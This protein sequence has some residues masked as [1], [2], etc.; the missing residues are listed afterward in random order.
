MK[1]FVSLCVSS[2][3]SLSYV[4]VRIL[5]SPTARNISG[6]KRSYDLPF[7]FISPLPK[8]RRNG[9][10]NNKLP[11]T[12]E[13]VSRA[14]ATVFR[15]GYRSTR[16]HSLRHGHLL[17]QRP[18]TPVTTNCRYRYRLR[19]RLRSNHFLS[20]LWALAKEMMKPLWATLGRPLHSFSLRVTH[21]CFRKWF[22][23]R[24]RAIASY[25]NM[26]KIFAIRLRINSLGSTKQFFGFV[27]RINP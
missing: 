24:G 2:Y 10:R 6:A 27:E 1:Q 22:R 11:L 26:K 4:T 20:F 21:K 5:H 16:C 23:V 13:M 7:P 17:A 3:K 14:I 9:Q 25:Y 18:S 8:A 12:K 19:L 15:S